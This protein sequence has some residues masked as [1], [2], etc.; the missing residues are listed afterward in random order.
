MEILP[1]S[2]RHQ[3]PHLVQHIFNKY[4]VPRGGIVYHNVGDGADELAIL[5]YR[6]AAHECGQVGTTII[7]RNLII[8]SIHRLKSKL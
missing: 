2:L 7:N 5:E 6:R 8:E 4:S 1:F 3:I